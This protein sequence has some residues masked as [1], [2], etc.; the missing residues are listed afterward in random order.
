MEMGV[1]GILTDVPDE[2]AAL[3]DDIEALQDGG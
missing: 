3:L 1:A 2:T